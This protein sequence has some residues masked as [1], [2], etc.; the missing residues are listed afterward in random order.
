[1]SQKTVLLAEDDASI[2]LIVNQTLVTAGYT[3]RATSSPEALERWVRNGEGDIVVTDVYLTDTPIFELLPSFKLVRPELPVIVM[4]GQNTILTAASAAQHGAYDYLP[5]P[6]DIDQLTDLVGRALS[7]AKPAP[8]IASRKP[9]GDASQSGLP[10]VGRSAVM[11]D[12]YRI[13]SRV[14]NTDLTVLIEGESGTGKELAARAIHD[15]GQTRNG[16]FHSLDLATSPPHEVSKEL[17]GS[18]ESPGLAYD[19]EAT[20]YLDE[21]GDLS[22]EAQTQLVKL[23]R[24]D[25][26]ARIVASTR[27]P[28][29]ALVESGDFREDL[30]YRMNVVRIEMPPLRRRKED[31]PELVKAF[32]IRAEA[33]GLAQKQIAQPAMDLMM[34]YDWPGNVRELENLIFRLAALSPDTTISQRDIER[35]LR[36]ETLKELSPEASLESEIEALLHRYVMAD[37]LKGGEEG[38]KIYQT[39]LEQV[40]RPLI[41]LA[42]S[43]TSGNKLRTAALLG[44]NRNTLRARMSVL[45]M[46]ED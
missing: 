3:V 32:L 34:A 38:E 28:L 24:E 26:G 44:V 31:I 6:F 20:I 35:E 42:L 45:G 25:G 22:Q 15:L 10:L 2:R 9:N 5:K 21:V 29:S 13:I 19:S 30:Y 37:L 7:D 1:M 36:A 4:S 46:T 11:Q 14:M 18:P 17:F 8:G 27:Q 41:K 16:A 43:V 12:V 33:R 40:E 23:M 39:V